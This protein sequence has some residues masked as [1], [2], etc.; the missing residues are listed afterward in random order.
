MM[1]KINKFTLFWLTKNFITFGYVSL[2]Q[3][4]WNFEHQRD[5]IDYL[6]LL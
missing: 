2:I 5:A 4:H 1:I 6:I 3:K